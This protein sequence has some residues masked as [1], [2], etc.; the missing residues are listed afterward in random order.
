MVAARPAITP[1]GPGTPPQRESL[2]ARASLARRLAALAYE[3][4]L[5]G[6]VLIAVG[7]AAAPLVSPAGPGPGPA[8]IPLPSAPARIAFFVLLFVVGAAYFGWSWTGGRRTLPMQTW[9]LRLVQTDGGAVTAGAGI[10]RYLAF[11][12][13]PAVAIAA[14]VALRPM[15]HARLALCLLAINYLWA[16]VDRDRQFLHDRIAGTRLLRVPAR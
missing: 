15:G 3:S 14:Y 9:R 8:A 11:W 6:A 12:I 16:L 4:L 7:F 1:P 5:L 10:R 2:P 13:G